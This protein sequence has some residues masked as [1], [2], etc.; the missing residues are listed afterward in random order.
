[1]SIAVSVQQYLFRERIPYDVIV[2]APT[3]DSAHSAE[4]A[5]ISGH[6]LAKSVVLQDENGYVM[7]VIPASHKLD[8]QAV[9]AELHR[10][11]SLSTEHTLAKLF[12]DCA[13]GAV[14][15]VPRVYGI[16]S[17]VDQTLTDVPEV[18]LEGGD[19]RS[20]IHLSVQE[21]RK[22]IAGSPQRHISHPL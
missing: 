1:M 2:H 6:R 11:L 3:W 20:L 16:Y 12:E 7:A 19:H 4:F 17:V 10:E 14:P 8:L 9:R 13:P 18:Y 22:V 5:H 15:P 21:F